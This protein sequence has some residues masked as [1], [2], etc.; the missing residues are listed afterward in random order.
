MRAWAPDGERRGKGIVSR[1]AFEVSTWTTDSSEMPHH[2]DMLSR[3]GLAFEDVAAW[4][5]IDEEGNVAIELAAGSAADAGPIW[6]AV[7]RIGLT[8]VGKHDWR[9]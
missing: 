9:C 3:L 1:P 4:L 8:P 5:Y 6:H 2:W 7:R